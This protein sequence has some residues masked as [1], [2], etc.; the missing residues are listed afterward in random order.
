MPLPK[1]VVKIKKGGVEYVSNVDAVN[2]SIVE[3]T[4]AA[5]RDVGKFI[6]KRTIEKIKKLPGLKRHRRP[7]NLQYWVRRRETDMLIGFKHDAWYSTG[8]EIGEKG[9]PK[10]GF[11]RDTTYDNIKTIV[12]IE[13]QYLSAL[14]KDDPSGLFDE[15]EILGDEKS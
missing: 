10:K 9:M 5:L 4:R 15:G 3:L 7:Y 11:L 2:Y 1:S 13:S 12:E 8:M 14:N 6:R